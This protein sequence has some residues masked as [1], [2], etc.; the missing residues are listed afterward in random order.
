LWW[1]G[2]TDPALLEAEDEVSLGQ[3]AGLVGAKD[4]CPLTQQACHALAVDV[5]RH[6]RVNSGEDVIN[7]VQLLGRSCNNQK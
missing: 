1:A 4:S 6:S 2:L 5:L 7:Q 3:V